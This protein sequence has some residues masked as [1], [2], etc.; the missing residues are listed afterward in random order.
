MKAENYDLYYLTKYFALDNPTKNY[1][2]IS[3]KNYANISMIRSVDN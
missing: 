1:V 3:K 2:D